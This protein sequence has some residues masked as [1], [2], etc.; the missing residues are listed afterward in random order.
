MKS[1]KQLSKFEPTTSNSEGKSLTFLET[2]ETLILSYIFSEFTNI[3]KQKNWI[4]YAENTNQ[5]LIYTLNQDAIIGALYS[6]RHKNQKRD[7]SL[8]LAALNLT[9]GV[10]LKRWW[11]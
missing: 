9:E 11:I 7:G 3:E 4:M 10:W 5:L 6:N 1:L 8:H 2:G